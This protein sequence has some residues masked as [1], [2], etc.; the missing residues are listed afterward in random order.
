[1]IL[2]GLQMLKCKKGG[3]KMDEQ[4]ETY[5]VYVKTDENNNITEVNS[6][7]FLTD[8]TD[9][10]QIDEGTGDKYHHAQGNY[11]D[12]AIS[13]A[14]GIYRYQW[15][16]NAVYEKTDAEIAAEEAAI[17]E[18]VQ[19]DLADTVRAQN[20]TITMMSSVIEDLQTDVEALQ[21]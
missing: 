8:T 14:K 12:K 4:R 3:L 13:T 19:I 9:W 16:S 20:A 21:V 5:I 2:S 7:A 11:F 18:T 10:A 15:V 1:M 17:V 6:S